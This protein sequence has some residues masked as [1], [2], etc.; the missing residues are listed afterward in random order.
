[1]NSRW[2]PNGHEVDAIL[3]IAVAT[4]FAVGFVAGLA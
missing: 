1:V 3:W 4:V 2:C